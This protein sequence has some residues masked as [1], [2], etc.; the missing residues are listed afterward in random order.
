MSITIDKFGGYR[1][2]IKYLPGP[3]GHG[4][5]LTVNSDYDI[6]NKR[7]TNVAL[8]KE[9]NDAVTVSYSD[10]KYV[11]MSEKGID[12]RKRKITNVLDPV[13]ESDV[14]TK[15]YNDSYL[16]K[17]FKSC[18]L[19]NESDNIINC[20]SFRISNI[21]NPS[22]SNDAVSLHYFNGKL[23]QTIV[24]ETKD[25]LKHNE[26][27]EIDLRNKK[28]YLDFAEN[29]TS[30]VTL[31]QI[32]EML[33]NYIEIN[34]N[35]EIDVRDAYIRNI[36]KPAR[37]H[38]A[39]NKEYVDN[40]FL[41]VKNEIINLVKQMV[42]NHISAKD[43]LID[44]NSKKI[45]LKVLEPS[46]TLSPIT[47]SYFDKSTKKINIDLEEIK[48]Y[49]YAYLP[50]KSAR[51]AI[52]PIPE[53]LNTINEEINILKTSL[54]NIKNDI[55]PKLSDIS[56]ELSNFNN[57]LESL[58]SLNSDVER[59]SQEFNTIK[60]DVSDIKTNIGNLKD[61]IDNVDT[62]ADEFWNRMRNLDN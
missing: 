38:D 6:D 50:T 37:K 22:D 53:T 4:F 54:N 59:V 47:L 46:D 56:N 31:K 16:N 17:K 27:N 15:G 10:S 19:F 25:H 23:R 36:K 3:S 1:T 28:I 55:P 62:D 20:K 26:N 14:V 43:G 24:E 51:S 30:P 61:A 5:K 13:N 12:A 48:N 40:L 60:R 18:V 32:G 41:S 39:S 29:P 44:F 34:L 45:N 8:P 58:G 57:K 21:E 9:N 7:L 49:L 42:S 33:I 11:T 2:G 52:T 35:N